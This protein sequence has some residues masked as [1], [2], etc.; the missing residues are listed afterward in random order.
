[1]RPMRN[2]L[3]DWIQD[4]GCLYEERRYL[5]GRCYLSWVIGYEKAT[6]D[7]DFTAKELRAIADYMDAHREEE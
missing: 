5:S 7:G 2:N 1:M 6:L 4:D 3:E